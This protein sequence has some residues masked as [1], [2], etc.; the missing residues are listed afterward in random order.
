METSVV[1]ERQVVRFEK[2]GDVGIIVIDN[3][4][5]NAGATSVR[6]GLL[7]AVQEFAADNELSGAILIGAGRMFMAGSDMREINSPVL[8][9]PLPQIIDAIQACPKPV[10]AAIAGAALGGGY[11]LS[12]GCDGRIASPEAV[13]G[14]PEC[15]LGM[16]PG[17]GGSQ[18]LP[19]L[20]GL[21]KAIELICGG[22]R[23]RADEAA[24]LG[25]ID[26][27]SSGVLLDDAIT[28]LRELSGS[29][30]RVTDL[31]APQCSDVELK[32]AMA[33]S[34]HSTGGRPNIMRAIEAIESC[35]TLP[36]DEALRRE[37]Q[38]FNELRTGQ[39][40]A[41]LLHLFFAERD[42]Q[43]SQGGQDENGAALV[44]RLQGA[45]G[46][47]CRQL[48]VRGLNPKRIRQALEN[49]GLD[50]RYAGQLDDSGTGALSD[51]CADWGE[52][53]VIQI[54]LA[55]IA[56]EA[57]LIVEENQ[58]DRVSD[59]D[60]F[61]TRL[62]GFPRHEGGI[63]FWSR[64]MGAENLQALF[65]ELSHYGSGNFQPGSSLSLVSSVTD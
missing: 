2:R 61:L 20:V 37:R 21:P 56:N 18:R 31:A 22:I 8:D 24:S 30:R 28:F 35:L 57:A 19:R 54:V 50:R 38:I 26:R 46:E 53:P 39:E 63:V 33:A 6:K 47:I 36:V 10:I 14:L 44:E 43:K 12:L 29:K 62:G 65:E 3:P 42:L 23:V 9:P 34:L 11:E 45:S 13:V 15:L 55:A 17:A 5:I 40:T 49:F 16:M 52:R 51:C 64:Q 32:E 58:I 7:N 25:M 59:L 60:V 48:Q 1:Q 4:P 27:I 41:A